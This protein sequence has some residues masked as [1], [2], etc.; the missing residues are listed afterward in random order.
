MLQTILDKINFKEK[1][2]PILIAVLLFTFSS[3]VLLRANYSAATFP[4]GLI[5]IL[6]IANISFK[7]KKDFLKD[8]FLFPI[9]FIE[10]EYCFQLLTLIDVVDEKGIIF[11]AVLR[12][13]NLIF[14][15][16]PLILGLYL[17][18]RSLFGYRATAAIV[19][20]PFALLTIIDFYTARFRGN[21][22]IFSDFRSAGTALN[23]AG[24]YSFDPTMPLALIVVPY[25]LTLFCAFNIVKPSVH[26]RLRERI[27]YAAAA[28]LSLTLFVYIVNEHSQKYKFE[29]WSYNGAIYNTFYVNFGMSLLKSIVITP[30]GYDLSAIDNATNNVSASLPEEP[31]NIIVVMNESYMDISLYHDQTGDIEDPDPY[32]DSL[33]ENTIHGYAFSSVFGG[34]TA[35][36][37]YEFLTGLSMADLPSG[38]VA[39]NQ[40]IDEDLPCLPRFLDNLG[41]STYA[42]HPYERSSWHR[43]T[44]YPLMDFQNML[45]V[46]EFDFDIDDIIRS[47]VSDRC[48]Y[49]NLL[50]RCD[51]NDGLGFYFLITMQNHGGFINEFN[52]I[53]FTP[54]VYV[55]APD[56]EKLNNYLTLIHESDL[57]LE[58][59]IEELENRDERYVLLVFGDHQPEVD[60]LETDLGVGGV[61]W[62]I[63]YIIW[64][65]FDMDPALTEELDHT[66]DYTSINYLSLDLLTVAGITPDPY[67]DL[68]YRIRDEVPCI[69]TMGYRLSGESEFHSRDDAE[70]NDMRRLYSYITYDVLFDEEDSAATALG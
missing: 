70:T 22:I 28:V 4:I 36:S 42:L 40:F 66:T 3:I 59:L 44:I 39:F 16:I 34:N 9:M 69:N 50:Q 41:Y 12:H 65:N 52:G 10:I 35:N 29:T 55:D 32:W 63:P 23:V 24:S 18:I 64:T 46:E 11:L 38:S 13:E 54:T 67:Y 8:L 48:A 57:A 37:E 27:I 15:T 33:T 21:E 47:N 17:L 45:F 58:H 14:K 20:I 68:L 60:F 1:K 2:I 5:V 49:D 56:T 30:T 53:N 31:A 25:I 43:D 51:A 61:S 62:V 19:P 7:G 6:S 26:R